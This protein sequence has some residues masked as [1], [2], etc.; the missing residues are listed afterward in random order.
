MTFFP[1]LC[2]PWVPLCRRVVLS[3]MVEAEQ[4]VEV[5]AVAAE[6][7][8]AAGAAAEAAAGQ[9]RQ[10]HQAR[11]V[12]LGVWGNLAALLLE[13]DRPHEALEELRGALE[14]VGRVGRVV[15]WLVGWLVGWL[16][17]GWVGVRLQWLHT[18]TARWACGE[19]ACVHMDPRLDLISTSAH[20]PQ[21]RPQPEPHL[22]CCTPFPPRSLSWVRF[23]LG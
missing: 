15:I 12:R 16:V 1:L 19:A 2:S 10:L 8:G 11:L 9:R 22:H 21:T 13:A 20:T 14:L 23:S 3:A 17:D 18:W 5:E 4:E 6:A 7:A